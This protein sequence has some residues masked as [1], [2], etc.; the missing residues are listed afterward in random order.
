MGRG[1]SLTVQGD[2]F[3][4][5]GPLKLSMTKQL[6]NI[7]KYKGGRLVNVAASQSIWDPTKLDV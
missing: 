5:G 6:L 3:E 4:P 7:V 1:P 2:Y